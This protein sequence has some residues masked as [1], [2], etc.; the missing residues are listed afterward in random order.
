MRPRGRDQ[1]TLEPRARRGGLADPRL[2]RR[3]EHQDRGA[4]AD[5]LEIGRRP[6]EL[7]DLIAR[8]LVAP[9]A[10]RGPGA[11]ERALRLGDPR[12]LERIGGE[13]ELGRLGERDARLGVRELRDRARRLDPRALVERLHERGRQRPEPIEGAIEAADPQLEQAI[14]LRAVHVGRLAHAAIAGLP[15]RGERVERRDGRLDPGGRAERRAHARGCPRVPHR[16]PSPAA[17]TAI[18]VRAARAR[19]DHTSD[20]AHGEGPGGDDRDPALPATIPRERRDQ[21]VHR[22]EALGRLGGERALD[23][24]VE[25]ARRLGGGRRARGRS[26]T[27][28][29]RR[30]RCGADGLRRRGGRVRRDRRAGGELGGAHPGDGLV[31]GRGRRRAEHDGGPCRADPGGAAGPRGGRVLRRLAQLVTR[32]ALV[33]AFAV[34]RLVQGDPEA[35][36]V[37]RGRGGRPGEHLGGHVHRRPRAIVMLGIVVGI[38][39]P[40]VDHAGAILADQDVVGLDVAM[41]EPRAMRGGEPGRGLAHDAEDIPPRPVAVDPGA[42]R[43]PGDE[44]H[45]DV[46]GALVLLGVVDRDRRW[47]GRA[48]RA[49]APRAATARSRRDRRRGGP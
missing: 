48:C 21:G 17:V 12:A 39:E 15:A 5:R 40:E 16:H 47:G 1:R 23:D 36:L 8:E 14:G 2:D 31:G 3:G 22:A 34:Q 24:R 46:H 49:R 32:A 43:C 10:V 41:D 45:H 33:R 42:Q 30:H 44:L 19:D 9:E 25:P 38:G 35:E 13:R 6:L 18:R 20:R 26:P 7:G 28:G 37:G 4:E 29:G 11:I 27:P